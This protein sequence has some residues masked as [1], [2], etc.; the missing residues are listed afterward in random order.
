MGRNDSL[1]TPLNLD[2]L[3]T[4]LDSDCGQSTFV[5]KLV[6]LRKFK[7]LSEIPA[8][9]PIAVSLNNN[10]PHFCNQLHLNVN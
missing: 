3:I 1:R 2:R 5:R 9:D 4:V 7:T 8:A 10:F 6:N